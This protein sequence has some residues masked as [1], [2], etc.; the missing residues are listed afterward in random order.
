M[1]KEKVKNLLNKIGKAFFIKNL[2]DILDNKINYNEIA[3]KNNISE[4]SCYTRISN[5]KRIIREN[6]IK[7]ALEICKESKHHSSN[8]SQIESL[9]KYDNSFQN[10]QIIKEIKF[11][12]DHK[13]QSDLS[14]LSRLEIIKLYADVVNE[15]R[16]RN[17]IRSAKVTGDLGENFVVNHFNEQDELENLELNENSSNKS[18]DAFEKNNK[19]KK[20]EIK[21]I[22]QSNTSDIKY[23]EGSNEVPFDYLIICKLD[24]NYY[25]EN[26]FRLTFEDFK[27]VKKAKNSNN[28][29][30]VKINNKEFLQLIDEHPE[31]V[32]I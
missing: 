32:L 25:V 16:N 5:I 18:Y 7:T 13:L 8:K 21:T 23:K 30:F 12:P 3:L 15:L 22:T 1:E 6:Q 20:Y 10:P 9:L 28:T 19:D 31:K 26:L 2:Q 27:K 4:T 11:I 24:R 29:W 14:F 17:I